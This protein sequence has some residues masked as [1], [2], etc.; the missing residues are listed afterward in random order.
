MNG[1]A[2]S[3]VFSG[4]Y[5]EPIGWSFVLIEKL[6]LH[7]LLDMWKDYACYREQVLTNFWYNSVFIG[8]KLLPYCLDVVGMRDAI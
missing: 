6:P 1:I 7:I 5:F 4:L 3:S 2:N 8:I